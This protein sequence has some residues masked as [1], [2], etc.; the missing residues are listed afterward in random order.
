MSSID[1]VSNGTT[2]MNVGH[3]Q[4]VVSP[5]GRLREVVK[6]VRVAPQERQATHQRAYEGDY[7]LGVE[8]YP[9]RRYLAQIVDGEPVRQPWT[10]ANAELYGRLMD[11]QDEVLQDWVAPHEPSNSFLPDGCGWT[12]GRTPADLRKR[13]LA[14][15]FF[16][17]AEAWCEPLLDQIQSS[18]HSG[19][20][21]DWNKAAAMPE[22]MD[23]PRNT[24]R[25]PG[26]E[27]GL[28][29]YTQWVLWFEDGRVE[30]LTPP[31]TSGHCT[32][33]YAGEM[34]YDYNARPLEMPY[35]VY[36]AVK[37]TRGCYTRRGGRESYGMRFELF[38]RVGGV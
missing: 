10:E 21:Y 24:R 30:A 38:S 29:I 17:G 14:M 5:A 15:E 12:D 20:H 3:R 18:P 27:N 35:D 13:A 9:E 25:V 2:R 7:I 11:K 22:V 32:T 33:L 34:S 28:D 26:E 8:W 19:L 6:A 16:K 4:V 37:V 1:P 36:R 23:C 31:A